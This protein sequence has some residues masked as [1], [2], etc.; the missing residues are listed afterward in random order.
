M[1]SDMTI[2]SLRKNLIGRI[3]LMDT[4]L[5]LIIEPD[6]PN[7]GWRVWYHLFQAVVRQTIEKIRY[8]W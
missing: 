5:V 8:I 4:S 1:A 3:E 6:Y 2:N 7:I